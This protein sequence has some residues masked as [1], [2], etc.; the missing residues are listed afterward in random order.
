MPLEIFILSELSQSQK[1]SYCTFFFFY[2]TTKSC[3]YVIK[4][5]MKLSRETKELKRGG[6]EKEGLREHD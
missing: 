4:V 6:G 1:D 5:K 2:S 3:I